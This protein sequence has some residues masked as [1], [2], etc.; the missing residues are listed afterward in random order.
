[1]LIRTLNRIQLFFRNGIRVLRLI[2]SDIFLIFDFNLYLFNLSE[3][4]ACVQ[5]AVLAKTL[6]NYLNKF[7]HLTVYFRH[8][9]YNKKSCR[10]GTASTDYSGLNNTFLSTRIQFTN[11]LCTN[12]TTAV[13]RII[14]SFRFPFDLQLMG[15]M[16]F[17]LFLSVF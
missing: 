11:D 10:Y 13:G 2:Q 4:T 3:I 15:L 17:H 8:L 9:V 14:L 16:L 12:I 6:E 7:R 5:L 1:M